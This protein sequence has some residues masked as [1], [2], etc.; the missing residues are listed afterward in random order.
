MLTTT[1]KYILVTNKNIKSKYSHIPDVAVLYYLSNDF[2][3]K[4]IRFFLPF[5]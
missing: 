2:M 5:R 3:R 4:A 1:A